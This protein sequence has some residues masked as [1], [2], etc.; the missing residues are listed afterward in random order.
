MDPTTNLFPMEVC[1]ANNQPVGAARCRG[2]A[3]D[4]AGP[5]HGSER[6]VSPATGSIDKILLLADI[7]VA[8]RPLG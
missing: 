3:Q 4:L 1:V 8:M 2:L 7:E 6:D 5:N